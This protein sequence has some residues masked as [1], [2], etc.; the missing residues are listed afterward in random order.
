MVEQR[1]RRDLF[2]ANTG[3]VISP[4]PASSAIECRANRCQGDGFMGGHGADGTFENE[5]QTLNRRHADAH[6]VTSLAS[7]DR[8]ESIAFGRCVSA[9]SQSTAEGASIPRLSLERTAPSSCSSRRSATEK[10]ESD[11]STPRM[12]TGLV[13]V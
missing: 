5:R 1:L 6:A 4:R 7:R 9:S 13:C 11:V 8:E 10:R 3:S 2:P 12:I